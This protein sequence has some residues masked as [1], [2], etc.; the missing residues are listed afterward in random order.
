MRCSQGRGVSCSLLQVPLPRSNREP[1]R[2][3]HLLLGSRVQAHAMDSRSRK[4]HDVV[5]RPKPERC[6]ERDKSLPAGSPCRNH[7][8]RCDLSEKRAVEPP[9]YSAAAVHGQDAESPPSP[10]MH[11]V[12]EYQRVRYARDRTGH[13]AIYADAQMQRV[14]I[15]T[16]KTV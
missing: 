1:P 3:R 16:F 13:L 9:A 4:V 14:G 15:L 2:G 10:R 5:G 6:I 7:R 12:I 11:D 8:A